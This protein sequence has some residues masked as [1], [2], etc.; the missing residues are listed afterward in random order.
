M[1]WPPVEL[2]LQ[3]ITWSLI[4]GIDYMAGVHQSTS[5]SSFPFLGAQ[6]EPKKDDSL[7]TSDPV[8]LSNSGKISQSNG[9]TTT[10]SKDERGNKID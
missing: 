9:N 2:M 3:L 6:Q 8:T 1:M 10:P 4:S 5:C 7:R